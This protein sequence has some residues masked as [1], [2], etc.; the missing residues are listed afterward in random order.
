LRFGIVGSASLAQAFKLSFGWSFD[1]DHNNV[2]TQDL[3]KM[4]YFR[5][6]TGTVYDCIPFTQFLQCSNGP[7]IISELFPLLIGKTSNRDIIGRQSSLLDMGSNDIP[8]PDVV[9]SSFY[10]DSYK[11]VLPGTGHSYDDDSDQ[12]DT[13]DK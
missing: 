6:T 12:S 5:Q 10:S 1:A 2:I 4:R 7:Y 3:F 9:E 11:D 13:S 8:H